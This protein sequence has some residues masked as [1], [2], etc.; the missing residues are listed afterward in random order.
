[1]EGPKVA[2]IVSAEVSVKMQLPAPVQPVQRVKLLFN[3]AVSVSVICVFA[4][5]LP[6]QVPLVQSIPAGVLT[7]VPWPVP[8]KV[9]VRVSLVTTTAAAKVAVTLSLDATVT[10]H[11]P[12]PEHPL[13]LHPVKVLPPVGAAVSVTCV[14]GAKLAEH[15]GVQ[16]MPPVELVTVPVPVP[17]KATVNPSPALN[18]A[19]TVAAAVRVTVHAPGPVQLPLQPPKK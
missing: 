9:T 8:A 15:V 16:L 14:F 6:V 4:G 18:T 13:P 11:V 19:L 12:V 2:V 7:T 17:A 3:P 10:L 5:K 1:L